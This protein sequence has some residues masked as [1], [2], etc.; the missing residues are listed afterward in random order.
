[1]SIEDRS[2]IAVAKLMQVMN[3][4]KTVERDNYCDPEQFFNARKTLKLLMKEV[5]HKLDYLDHA[6]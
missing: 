5:E 3:F 1:M 4:I 6:F 2:E